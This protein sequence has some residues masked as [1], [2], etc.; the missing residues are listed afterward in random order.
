MYVWLNL[1]VCVSDTDLEK[2]LHSLFHLS[3]SVVYR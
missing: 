3:L 2:D 1:P